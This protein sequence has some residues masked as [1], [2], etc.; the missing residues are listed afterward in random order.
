MTISSRA[1]AR[2]G[3]HPGFGPWGGRVQGMIGMRQRQRLNAKNKGRT[4]PTFMFGGGVGGSGKPMERLIPTRGITEWFYK[5]GVVKTRPKCKGTKFALWHQHQDAETAGGI[6]TIANKVPF[7][8]A[9]V[10]GFTTK[11]TN[12]CQ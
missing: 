12:K 4:T 8:R 1:K 2:T 11:V 6:N 7:N 10:K 5:N 9:S 3:Y